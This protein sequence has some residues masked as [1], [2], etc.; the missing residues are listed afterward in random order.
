VTHKPF[1]NPVSCALCCLAALFSQVCGAAGEPLYVGNVDFVRPTSKATVIKATVKSLQAHFPEREV[2]LV[3]IPVNRLESAIAAGKIDI[4]IT[5][6]GHSFRLQQKHGTRVIGTLVTRDYP[7]PNHSEG[8]AIL[9]R[10]DDESIRALADLRGRRLAA[11]TPVSFT[12]Y[13]I[14]MGEIAKI[15]RDWEHFFSSMTFVGGGAALGEALEAVADGKADAAFSRICYWE[16]WA[17]GHPA[18]AAKLRVLNPM[19]GEGEACARSSELYPNWTVTATASLSAEDAR[20]AAIAIMNV[21]PDEN[22]NYWGVATDF[23]HVDRLFERLR[24]GKYAYLRQW[25]LKGFLSTYWP[26]FA[27]A[28][29]ALVGLVLHSRRADYLVQR[30]TEQLQKLMA[31]QRELQEKARDAAEH[32]EAL[33]KMGA[34]GQV[35]GMLAHEMKQPLAAISFYLDGLRLLLK[36]G[37]IG[38][39]DLLEE[40]LSE[41]EVQMRKADGIV[42]HARQYARSARSGSRRVWCRLSEVLAR[43]VENYRV[44]RKCPPAIEKDF[45]GADSWVKV[46]PLE[47]ECAVFNL[48]KNAGEAAQGVEHPTVRIRTQREDDRI[49]VAIEDNGPELSD[50]GF[51]R[52]FTPQASEKEGGLGLGLSIV[53]SLVEVYGSKLSFDRM[54]GGGLR[55]SFSLSCTDSRPVEEKPHA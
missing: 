39:S 14:P 8:A 35:S 25:T 37:A 41:I 4:F 1:L 50:E 24:I 15:D 38:P 23:L 47:L 9:V 54:K 32:L 43:T 42:E 16:M 34:L 52:L 28:L 48:L 6:A 30:R 40:P 26:A 51:A 22:G 55:A 53:R 5:S 49:V 17:K 44:S 2:Q 27:L 20:R 19:T 13:H 21:K 3:E 12:G 7:D 10:R 36:R 45:A 31:R 29:L 46:D 18:A 11:N 33:Q